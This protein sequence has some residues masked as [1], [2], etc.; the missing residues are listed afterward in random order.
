MKKKKKHYQKFE[1]DCSGADARQSDQGATSGSDAVR[2]VPATDRKDRVC[3][4]KQCEQPATEDQVDRDGRVW[5]SLCG[6]HHKELDDSINDL[7]PRKML[8]C[9]VLAK[10]GSDKA[11]S[12]FFNQKQ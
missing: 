6:E 1:S 7:N 8:Q 9:W 4:W 5:A 10:G 3:T 12:E 2:S 11:A